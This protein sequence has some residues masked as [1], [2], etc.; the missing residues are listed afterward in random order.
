MEKRIS[1]VVYAGHVPIGGGHPVTVQSMLNVRTSDV[2]AALGQIHALAEAGAG[3]VRLSVDS[4]ADAEALRAIVA[5]SPVP[6]VADIQFDWR[7][8]LHALDAGAAAVRLNPGLFP[9]GGK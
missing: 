8:A 6:L 3:I 2:D 1:R 7:S 9:S 5:A 4:R